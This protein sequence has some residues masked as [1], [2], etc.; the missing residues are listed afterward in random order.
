M[1]GGTVY[2]LGTRHSSDAWTKGTHDWAPRSRQSTMSW[3]HSHFPHVNQCFHQPP[4]KGPISLWELLPPIGPHV[5]LIFRLCVC[6]VSNTDR[7][8]PPTWAPG[9]RSFLGCKTQLCLHVGPS[10]L[11]LPPVPVSGQEDG[12]AQSAVPGKPSHARLIPGTPCHPICLSPGTPN[13]GETGPAPLDCGPAKDRANCAT[14]VTLCPGCS[15]ALMRTSGQ[16]EI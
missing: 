16:P 1:Q 8:I 12:T 11:H 15:F 5:P 10:H 6:E 2:H 3:H 9:D 4:N 13:P 7:A 14:Q